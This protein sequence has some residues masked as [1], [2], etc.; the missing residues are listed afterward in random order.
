MPVKRSIR[1]LQLAAAF[2]YQL[3]VT[4]PID[5]AQWSRPWP[6][7]GKKMARVR[8]DKL[9]ISNRAG[10]VSVIPGRTL[11]ALAEQLKPDGF[12]TSI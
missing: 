7:G 9:G 11:L 6:A 2:V 3:V 1:P 8:G 10:R 5:L 4:V 12:T